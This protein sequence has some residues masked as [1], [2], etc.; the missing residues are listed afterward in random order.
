[1]ETVNGLPA[2]YGT[3][4]WNGR[5]RAY[6]SSA[7]G[8]TGPGG[9]TGG[10]A[11]AQEPRAKCSVVD[12]KG[13]HGEVQRC[14]PLPRWGSEFTEFAIEWDGS[15]YL[16]FHINGALVSTVT[17]HVTPPT[18]PPEADTEHQQ[19][20]FYDDPMFLML[21][22]AVGG[23]WPGEPTDETALPALHLVDY[24]RWETR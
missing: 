21:Q 23:P 13:G 20:V 15:T 7:T 12:G 11:P 4:H 6:R 22:T 9:E 24:V 5:Y 2:W 14:A 19:V 10:G 8:A 1:M 18:K 17:A 16:S 3:Y